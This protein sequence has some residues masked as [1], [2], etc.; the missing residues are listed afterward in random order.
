MARNIEIKACAE[1]FQEQS[2]LAE[3]ISDSPVEIIHQED[4]FFNVPQGKLKLR[5]FSE[6]FAQL[7]Y[8]TR[9]EQQGPK[10]SNY[11]ISETSDPQ[12]L[13]NILHTAYGIRNTVIKVRHL[14]MFGRTRIH[15][16]RVESLGDFIELEVVLAD[17]DSIID[18]EKET[19]MLMKK[20]GILSDHLIEGA[21]ID[22]IEQYI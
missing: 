20:L 1:K 9:P 2:G 15:F 10:L 22:L 14:Y 11:E 19:E 8:Y 7:I 16:D 6:D 4:V 13:K 18:G 17:G 5:I 3:S 21:Y 12:G